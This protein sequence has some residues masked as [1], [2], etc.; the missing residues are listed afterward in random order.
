MP[1]KVVGHLKMKVIPNLETGTNTNVVKEQLEPPVELA[2]DDST[3]YIRFNELVE[4]HQTVTYGREAV[5]NFL[6]CAH[7]AISNAKRLL[8]DVHHNLKTEHLQYYLG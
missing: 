7:I 8:L 6:P 2:T 4:S 1:A 5:K 3:S